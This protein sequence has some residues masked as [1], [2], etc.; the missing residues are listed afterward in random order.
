[1]REKQT[2]VAPG[3]IIMSGPTGRR[4]DDA[5]LGLK[6]EGLIAIETNLDPMSL[7]LLKRALGQTPT[8]IIIPSGE[9]TFASSIPGEDEDA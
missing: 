2:T 8:P 6:T 7:A 1:M 9:R 4:S 5:D 3:L